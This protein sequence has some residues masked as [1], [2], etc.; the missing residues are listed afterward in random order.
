[1]SAI[2]GKADIEIVLRRGR[3]APLNAELRESF[4]RVAMELRFPISRCSM[5]PPTQ[6]IF[7]VEAGRTL[8]IA[9]DARR[10]PC[11]SSAV[12]ELILP[13]RTPVD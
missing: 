2:G 7:H 6:N 13:I 1:M 8:P 9:S 12:C 10:L 5:A 3:M 11:R 4:R